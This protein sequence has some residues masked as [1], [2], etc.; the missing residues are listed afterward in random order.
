MFARLLPGFAW[1]LPARPRLAAASRVA[2]LK[3]AMQV[4][5]TRRELG[6][7]DGRMLRDV[8]LTPEDVRLEINRAPWDVG[9]PRRGYRPVRHAPSPLGE[10]WRRWRT[11]RMLA[12]LDDRAL[13]D[14]GASREQARSEAAKPFWQ[15]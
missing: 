5:A 13:R 11:R 8:G 4:I 9:P 6:E 1:H 7:L 14:I 3:R 15:A 10:A 2:G 12:D